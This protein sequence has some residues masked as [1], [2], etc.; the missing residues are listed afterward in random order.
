MLDTFRLTFLAIISCMG[1]HD[2]PVP[3]IFITLSRKDVR[4]MPGC[5]WAPYE[6]C[7]VL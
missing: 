5:V 2:H 1:Q 7:T 4:C 6:Y 3:G